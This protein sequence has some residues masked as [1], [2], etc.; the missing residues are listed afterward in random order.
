MAGGDSGPQRYAHLGLNLPD[1]FSGG[2]SQDSPPALSN[3]THSSITQV[4]N[5]STLAPVPSQTSTPIDPPAQPAREKNRA[6][7]L[8]RPNTG[9]NV[10][11]QQTQL[12]LLRIAQLETELAALKAAQPH[13]PSRQIMTPA[14]TTEFMTTNTPEAREGDGVVMS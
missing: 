3:N 4:S 5:T 9:L 6:D 12:C 1:P 14:P 8:T 10:S 13:V 11:G 2:R 7:D